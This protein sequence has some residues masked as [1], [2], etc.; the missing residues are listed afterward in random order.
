MLNS[1]NVVVFTEAPAVGDALDIRTVTLTSV[2]AGLSAPLG[3]V[4]VFAEN[5]GLRITTG[6]TTAN[7]RST[8]LNTGSILHTPANLTVSTSPT[9]M[10]SF[11]KAV[12]RSAKYIVNVQAGSEFETSE[13]MVLHDGTTAYRTQYNK[14]YSG[15]ASLG[16]V[17]A[18]VVGANVYVYYTGVAATNYVQV[19]ADYV[20]V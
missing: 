5:A 9:I 10:D 13:V 3:Y 7:T 15:A 11:D 8:V 4:Q 20:G 16:S 1:A 2:I 14:I 6:E 12:I 17:T 18:A 19:K